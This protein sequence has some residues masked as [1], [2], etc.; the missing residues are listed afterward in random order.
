MQVMKATGGT[1]SI[2]RVENSTTLREAFSHAI[3]WFQDMKCLFLVDDSWPTNENATDFLTHLH[4]LLQESLEMAASTRSLNI[5][6]GVGVVGDCAARDPLGLCLLLYSQRTRF[7][8][9]LKRISPRV[10]QNTGVC[11]ELPIDLSVAGCVV[12]LLVRYFESF[13]PACE[14]YIVGA[15][16]LAI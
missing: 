5:V 11:G 16:D 15:S 9:S 1:A 4:H 14:F 2:A 3:S 10:D 6:A 8:E 7:L 12:A 13:H